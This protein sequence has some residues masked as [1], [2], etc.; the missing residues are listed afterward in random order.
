MSQRSLLKP[1]EVNLV[2]S[3]TFKI[4]AIP[5]KISSLKSPTT[6]LS[7]APRC[8]SELVEKGYSCHETSFGLV[9]VKVYN[10]EYNWEEAK[11]QCSQDGGELPMPRNSAENEWFGNKAKELGITSSFLLGMSD[12]DLEGTW[13]NQSGLAQTYFNWNRGEPNSRRVGNCADS[14][15]S[16]GLTWN[17]ERCSTD[18]KKILCTHIKGW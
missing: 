7:D 11:T 3:C 2:S 1:I 18:R 4:R 9:A 5:R 13:I 12:E 16:W 15:I 17:D 6:S 8:D 10:G 14:I